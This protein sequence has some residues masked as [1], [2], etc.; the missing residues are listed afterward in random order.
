MMC[1]VLQVALCVEIQKEGL[2]IR[3]AD[4][5]SAIAFRMMGG[6]F[7][8]LK[9]CLRIIAYTIVLIASIGLAMIYLVQHSLS[10]NW[11]NLPLNFIV[12]I[13]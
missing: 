11:L 9:S 5:A 2:G 7:R 6:V 4:G 10:A 8:C 12:G 1:L 13:I 3:L